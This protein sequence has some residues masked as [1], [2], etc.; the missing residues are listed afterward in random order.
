M[1]AQITLESIGHAAYQKMCGMSRLM[2]KSAWKGAGRNVVGYVPPPCYVA[3]IVG[4]DNRYGYARRFVK[5]FT[6][7]SKANSKGTRGVFRTYFIE[8]G[9]V[10]EVK[11]K[12]SWKGA[13][14]YYC[15]VD[16]KSGEIWKISKDDVDNHLKSLF[17]A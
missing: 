2:D 8:S 16:C 12:T 11:E 4:F 14:I 17:H 9:S 13:D 10:Y 3:E 1:K 15:F 5:G 7:Y 6:D